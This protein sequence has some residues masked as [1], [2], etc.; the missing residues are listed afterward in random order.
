MRW[1]HA[2]THDISVIRDLAFQTWPIAYGDILSPTQMDYMLQLFYSE[3]ALTT[4]MQQGHQ[5]LLAYQDDVPAGFASYSIDSI[6]H[7]SRLHKLYVHPQ[8]Q[9]LGVGQ[10][11][12]HAV[13]QQVSTATDT[14][15]LNVNRHNRALHFYERNHFK[16]IRTEDI[17]IGAGYYMN[18]YVM[19][20]SLQ[21]SK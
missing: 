10:T 14:L 11:L 21:V 4:Q 6:R 7:I 17:D 1:I 9:G 12:L 16:I 2:S 13:I 8:Y 19:A 3:E 18:D 20:L 5:F 15:E